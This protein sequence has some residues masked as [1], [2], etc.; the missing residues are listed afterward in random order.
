LGLADESGAGVGGG[1][2]KYAVYR[3]TGTDEVADV[4][5]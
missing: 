4:S 3:E 1:H 2:P 5:A